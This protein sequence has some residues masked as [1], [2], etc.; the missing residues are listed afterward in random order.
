[1]DPGQETREVSSDCKEEKRE[2]SSDPDEE[3]RGAS[4]NPEKET[5][6]APSDSE[7]ATKDVAGLAAGSMGLKGLVVLAR[8]KLTVSGNLPPNNVIAYVE[9]TSALKG[10][11]RSAAKYSANDRRG[12]RGRRK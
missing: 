1:M 5:H 9:S 3:T 2:A 10:G 6:E 12:R 11:R 7:G 8:R 4:S